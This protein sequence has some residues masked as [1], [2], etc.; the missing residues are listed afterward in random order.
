MSEGL[1]LAS[2]PEIERTVDS[3]AHRYGTG[4]CL[5]YSEMAELMSLHGLDLVLFRVVFIFGLSEEPVHSVADGRGDI[6]I[7]HNHERRKTNVEIVGHSVLQSVEHINLPELRCLEIYLVLESR[8]VSERYLFVEFLLSDPVLLLE[9]IDC[10]H[11]E[12]DVRQ[13]ERIG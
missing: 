4:I 10:A 1:K 5:G 9:R 12:R 11:R 13:G 6:D 2:F 7:F 3:G 8:A